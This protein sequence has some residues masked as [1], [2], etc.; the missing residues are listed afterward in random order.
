MVLVSLFIV[1]AEVV[2][3]EPS[4]MVDVLF[5][6]VVGGVCVL[7]SL[8]VVTFSSSIVN[9]GAVFVAAV[10]GGL[11]SVW[12]VVVASSVVG[13]LVVIIGDSV[14][15][16]GSVVATCSGVVSGSVVI[17]S[18]IVVGSVVC[19]SVVVCAIV[20]RGSV[21]VCVSVVVVYS[22]AICLVV[23]GDP[24]VVCCSV[25]VSDSVVVKNSVVNI[26]GSLGA[27]ML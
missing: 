9:E 16:S 15:V 19:D 13:C 26:S 6:A 22:V 5:I 2:E 17:C 23:T 18:S 20:V 24:V 25:V 12:S 4:G 7:E 10:A 27:V 11:S 21:V 1:V 8:D 3:S 14:E